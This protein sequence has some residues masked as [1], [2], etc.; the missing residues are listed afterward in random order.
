MIIKKVLFI[1]FLILTTTMFSQ[2]YLLSNE[3]LIYSFETVGGK[4]MTLAKDA[5]NKYIV[6][7]FGTKDKIEFEYPEKSKDSWSKFTYSF[8]LRGGGIQNEAMDLNYIYFTNNNYTYVIYDVYHV[9]EASRIGL[10]IIDT[11]TD[12][13][14]DIKG[15]KRTQKGTLLD[16]RFNEL[17]E[18]GEDIFD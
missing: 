18:I 7:R 13:T 2:S 3:K 14:I 8:Y 4:K 17:L 9:R 15:K 10:K 6:Y 16:F 12:K 11:K 1:F 5:N